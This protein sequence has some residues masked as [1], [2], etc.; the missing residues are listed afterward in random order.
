MLGFKAHKTRGQLMREEMGQSWDHF[1]QAA[2]HAAG[3]VGTKMGPTTGMMRRA[4]SGG[5]DST[6]STLA[7]LIAAYREGAANATA[8]AKKVK[9]KARKK[10]AQVSHRNTKM[11]V[12][13]L[14][15]GIAA[16]AV[17]AL[18]VKRRKQQQWSEYDPSQA[19]ESVR[20]EGRSAVDKI[21]GKADSAIDKATHHASKA[22]DK[23]A[24][25]LHSAS[26]SLKD[27]RSGMKSKV[28]D[29]AE[30]A[31]DATDSFVAKYSSSGSKNSRM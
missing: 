3:G 11:L 5:I 29:M 4:T 9:A 25:K 17:G 2:T 1:L 20:G 14:A 6:M 16:G 30:S 13:L 18:V 19:L 26:S 10:E 22:M 12:G 27:S 28:D 24:D 23:T 21:S 8:T 7:P 15:A 31:S